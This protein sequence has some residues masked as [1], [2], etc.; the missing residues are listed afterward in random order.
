MEA[1]NKVIGVGILLIAG[2]IIYSN[3][4]LDPPK[5][6]GEQT[7]ITPNVPVEL[8]EKPSVKGEKGNV[9]I[10]HIASGDTLEF[11]VFDSYLLLP[12]GTKSLPTKLDPNT[13]KSEPIWEVVPSRPV[14][15]VSLGNDFGM[16]AGFLT[17]KSGNQTRTWDVG[18]KYSPVRFL[19]NSVA[20]DMLASDQSLGIGLSFYPAPER[21]G[22]FWKHVGVGLGRVYNYSDDGFSNI[23]YTTISTRF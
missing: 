7:I 22:Y 4:P 2:W 3:S 23:I 10:K 21:Y 9:K 5:E 16:Y 19:F 13:G 6:I 11:D 20:L 17:S 1:L 14:S 18:I 15:F 8:I 12:T